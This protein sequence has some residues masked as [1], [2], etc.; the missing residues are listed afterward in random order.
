MP[1]SKSKPL[2]QRLFPHLPV[3]DEA[4]QQRLA[5][6]V[7]SANLLRFRRLTAVIVAAHLLTALI[8]LPSM[9][10][11]TATH[12]QRDQAIV[13]T[14]LAASILGAAALARHWAHASIARKSAFG[15]WLTVS[16]LLGATAASGLDV[17]AGNSPV[18][19]LLL[20]FAAGL[21]VLLPPVEA[22]IAAAIGIVAMI[23]GIYHFVP[24]ANPD[25]AMSVSAD[26]IGFCLI[27]W[28]IGRI[29]YLQEVHSFLLTQQLA[30]QQ[31]ELAEAFQQHRRYSEQLEKAKAELE[32]M[33][34]CDG[35]TGAASRRKLF[36]VGQAWQGAL[37]IID[38]D[39]FKNVNDSHGHDVGDLVLIE[40]VRR[41]QVTAPAGS[42]VAR[43][44]GEEFVVLLP[45]AKVPEI[46]AATEA[47]RDAV[48]VE[49]V[50]TP[51]ARLAITV[52]IG[53]AP[54]GGFGQPDLGGAL[55]LADEGL[56]SAKHAGRNRIGPSPYLRQRSISSIAKS[57]AG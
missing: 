7:T 9:L 29:R 28:G 20:S 8:Y 56:Y 41:L 43:L 12:W 55:L 25:R 23:A 19:Y 10:R 51:H 44:G 30:Q 26:A 14:L 22:L 31:A 57:A 5:H 48:A 18:T 54:V 53:W 24:A 40:L 35:L 38:I 11:G 49:P 47:L 15:F 33:V 3:L 50:A 4:A 6:E 42:L 16:Y 36:S 34:E 45:F 46:E 21:V 52:S 32:R 37:A 1:Q 27:G 13:Q 2:I 17:G 39:F